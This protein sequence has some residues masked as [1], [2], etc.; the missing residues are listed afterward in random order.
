VVLRLADGGD[1]QAALAAA[2]A[3]GPVTRFA[4]EQ[5]RLSELFLEAVAA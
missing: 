2:Q 3:A 5:P 1:P 4:V